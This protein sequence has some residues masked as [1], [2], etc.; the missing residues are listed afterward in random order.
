MLFEKIEALNN[1]IV[2]P[3]WQRSGAVKDRINSQE[4]IAKA[5]WVI[6]KQ[7]PNIRKDGTLRITRT[8]L[9]NAL[10]RSLPTIDAYIEQLIK[11]GAIVSREVCS[12]RFSI[13]KKRINCL[14][15]K[16]N[17]DFFIPAEG[18]ENKK[19]EQTKP[20]LY[21]STNIAKMSQND[22]PERGWVKKM[23]KIIRDSFGFSENRELGFSGFK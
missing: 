1:S 20:Q 9:A 14:L 19:E 15:L 17:L 7:L 5:W 2:R 3:D 21:H 23:E 10:K 13:D 6:M 4:Y 11:L 12:H 16:I 8:Y 22:V 18:Q